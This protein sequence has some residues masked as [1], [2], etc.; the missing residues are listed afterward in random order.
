MNEEIKSPLLGTRV[1]K[2]PFSL[3]LSLSLS[4]SFSLSLSFVFLFLKIFLE[5][6]TDYTVGLCVVLLSGI[7]L[8]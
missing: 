5:P 6:R 4:R 2:H 3:S 7:L 1:V 8:F